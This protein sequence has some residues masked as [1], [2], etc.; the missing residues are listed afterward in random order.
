MGFSVKSLLFGGVNEYVTM[1]NVLDREKTDPFSISYWVK[2]STVDWFYAVSKMDSAVTGYSVGPYADGRVNLTLAYAGSTAYLEVRANG[3]NTN[4]GSWHHVV[5][6]SDGTG[7]SGVSFVIDGVEITDKTVVNDTLGANLITNTGPFN[8]NGRT[9]GA[10]GCGAAMMDEVA[11]YNRALSTAEAAWIY[12]SGE[13]RDLSLVAAPPGLVGWW[14]MGEWTSTSPLLILDSGPSAVPNTVRDISGNNYDG[15]MTSMEAADVVYNA[16]GRGLCAGFNG[17]SDITTIAYGGGVKA[18]ERTDRFSVSWWARYN[19]SGTVCSK[20]S[21]GYQGWWV[22]NGSAGCGLILNNA[23][24]TNTLQK[25]GSRTGAAFSTDQRWHH[26]LITYNGSSSASGVKVYI[27]GTEADS[28]STAYDNLTSNIVYSPTDNFVVGTVNSTNYFNG[29]IRDLAIWGKTLS[30]AEATWLYNS[31]QPRDPYDQ[32][33]PGNLDGWWRLGD[34]DKFPEFYDSGPSA[35]YSSVV[36]QSFNNYLGATVNMEVEDVVYD[37]PGHGKSVMFDGVNEYATAGNVLGYEYTA[38]FSISCWFKVSTISGMLVT[39]MEADLSD[40]LRGYGIWLRPSGAFS[41]FLRN[42]NSS[43]NRIVVTSTTTGLADGTWHHVVATWK[44]SASPVASDVHLY[45]DGVLETPVVEAN[46]LTATITTTAPLILGTQYNST[47]YLNGRLTGVAI[48]SKELSAAEVEWIYNDGV[49]PDLLD[50]GAPSSLA[51][52]WKCGEGDTIPTLQDSGPSNYDATTQNMESYDIVADSPADTYHFAQKSYLFDGVSESVSMGNV[53]SFERTSAFS[54]SFWFKCSTPGT[55]YVPL[56]KLGAS[57]VGYQISIDSSGRFALWLVSNLGGGNYIQVQ[58]VSGYTNS[59]WRHCVVTFDGS[60][61]ATG[62]AIYIDGSPVTTTTVVNSLTGTIVNSNNFRLA[63]RDDGFYPYAGKL[64]EVSVYSRALTASE[65][66]WIYNSGKPRDLKNAPGAPL[67]LVGWWRMGEGG[68]RS[69]SATGTWQTRIL[70]DRPGLVSDF[71]TRCLAFDGGAEY[72]DFGNVLAFERN[73][74]FSISCWARWASDDYGA[75]VAKEDASYIGYCLYKYPGGG[76]AFELHGTGGGYINTYSSKWGYGNGGWHH[77]VATYD[78]SSTK[79]GLKLYIDNEDVNGGGTDTLVASIVTTTSLRIGQRQS[80]LSLTGEVDEVS[81]YNKQ[82][83]STEVSWIFNSGIPR[84]LRTAEAPSNL[85]GWWRLG[86]G[87]YPGTMTNMEA[88]DVV[89]DSPSPAQPPVN[90]FDSVTVS[91][92]A[93]TQLGFVALVPES[94]AVSESAGTEQ[95]FLLGLPESVAVSESP[96]TNQ[97]Y[98]LPELSESASISDFASPAQGQSAT[99]SDTVGVSESTDAVK[100]YN[101]TSTENISVAD[102]IGTLFVGTL[103]ITE[104]VPLS[105]TGGPSKSYYANVADV[106][107]V[108]EFLSGDSYEEVTEAIGFTEQVAV[109]TQVYEEDT[110]VTVTFPNGIQV[111]RVTDLAR[112]RFVPRDGTYPLTPL[113]AEPIWEVRASG[114]G[115]ECYATSDAPFTRLFRVAVGPGP[116]SAGD[117][118]RFSTAANGSVLARITNAVGHNVWVAQD[119]VA[120]DPENGSITWDVVRVVGVRIHV[121]KPLNQSWHWLYLTGLQDRN[122][123]PFET[124]SEF[125]VL[126]NKPTLTSAEFLDEGQI[127][128]TFSD[129]M[130]NDASLTDP[131]EYTV[132]GPTT[133]RVVSVRMLSPTQVFLQTLGMA[134]GVYTVRVNALGTPKDIAGNPID[135]VFNEAVFTGSEPTTL[136]SVFTDK[137]PIAK[138]PLT[139]QS[140][141]GAT[142]D[143]ATEITLPG[144]VLVPSM[145][146]KYVT[147]SGVTNGG[148]YLITSVITT[149]RAK[150]K[151]SFTY[152]DPDSGT[153]T[154]EVYDPRDGQ[155]ADDPADVS[156]TVNSAPITPEAVIGLLG[157]IVLTSRPAP[158]DDVQVGYSWVCNPTVEVRRL[159]SKEF[160]LNSWNRDINYPNDGTQHKYRYN[161]ILTTPDLYVPDDPQAWLDQPQQR[162][163]KYR[164]YERAYSALLND[165]NLLLLNSP[166]QKIAFPPLQ[167]TIPSTFVSYDALVL[168]EDDTTNPWTREGTGTASV[169]GGELL[170][171]DTQSG[172][173]PTGQPIFWVRP[174]DLTFDHVFAATWRMRISADPV[175]EGV[176]TGVAMGYSGGLKTLLIGYLDDAGTKKLGILKKGCGN[177]LQPITAW[178][179][180]LSGGSSTGAP[181]TF[182]WSILHSFRIYRDRMGIVRVY[183]DGGISEILRVSEDD[184]PFLEELAAPFDALEGVF[185]GSLSRPALNTSHWNFVRYTVLPTNPYQTAPSVFVSYEGTAFPESASQPWTPIGYHGTETLLTGGY[186]LLDSTSATDDATESLVG[187]IGGDFKGFLRMEPLLDVAS[188]IMLDVNVQLR[189][190]THGV[191]PN[192][193]TAAIDDGDRLMQLS[194]LCDRAAPKLSYGGRSFPED[195]TPVPWTKVATGAATAAMVGRTLR[196]TDPDIASGLIYY[197][198]DSAPDGSDARII[199]TSNEYAFEYRAQVIS[200]TA[201]PGGFCGVTADVYDSYATLGV[202]LQEVAG[203]R[204]VTLHSDGVPVVG[205]QFAF[206]WF[207]GEPHTYRVTKRG[208]PALV[209]LF[210]D[211]VYVGSVDYSLF[212]VPSPSLPTGVISFGSSTA[213]STLARSVV[214]WI[215]CNTWRVLSVFRKYVGLW[216]GYDPNALT[217]YHL[218]T[219]IT[220][221]DALVMGNVLGDSLANFFA[222]SVVAG[223]LLIV[224][225]GPNKGVYEVAAVPTASTLT[226]SGIFPH[227]PSQVTYRIAKETDWTTA[228]KYRLTKDAGG[229]VSVLLDAITAP[230][231]SVGYNNLE[232]PSSLVGIFRGITG[233]LPLIAF[234]AF[235]PTNISQTAWDYVRFGIVRSPTELR[236]VPH[237]QILNQRNV[238]AS[239]EHLF[240]AI[241]HTHTDYWSSST[242]IPPQTDPD[243]LKN[244]GLIAF[245]LLNEGTPLVPKTQTAETRAG[246][247]LLPVQQPIAGLNNPEDV[248]GSPAFVLNEGAYQWTLQVPDD[249]LYTDGVGTKTVYRNATPLP[250]APALQTEATFKLKLLNDSS[251]GAGDTQVR[252]GLSAPG[253]TLALLFKTTPLGERYVLVKDMNSGAIVGG[254]PFDFGDGNYHTYRIVRN[255][256]LASV[257][258]FI[259]P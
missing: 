253:M 119:L 135:L 159:N 8:I 174:V 241:A 257:Q 248:L 87:A 192:A 228:H 140:G 215:Y 43:G 68:Y 82:L 139:L 37:A 38:S 206:D 223:D 73:Q 227:N 243:F 34:G 178:T 54:F 230:I 101:E 55:Y 98:V 27:D 221:R 58:T 122:G 233:G 24:G 165:P 158:M 97:G 132:T 129:A 71:A 125:T 157:Q 108:S 2:R 226:I 57:L 204:Y 23:Y 144:S 46:G 110:V 74:P 105:E 249:V 244:P 117:Y 179:G 177:N 124:S 45:L 76:V 28:Y 199:G 254:V 17:T 88:G 128:L 99:A 93:T 35:N 200:Y 78:G 86:E 12:N 169:S 197:V 104:N 189:T 202:L 33:Y 90:L 155:I 210:I 186:L 137:G 167:R 9:N 30:A 183:V 18:Y 238:M 190:W 60:S 173:F 138:P 52:W 50:V 216:K 142:I 151:A 89:D 188:D 131:R 196:V 80:D 245:T 220:G 180:G 115:G 6:I 232:L 207:D 160:R 112:Y 236:I 237:H 209:S 63:S 164:A 242:G 62:V 83:T 21:A 252:F 44:G 114:S 120:N 229:S 51:A 48:H 166:T 127:I 218:P 11:F 14:R 96:A 212:T 81:I 259:D 92:G 175:D 103:P 162:D 70:G 7:G 246:Y 250:D 130:R 59:A 222:S 150:V 181:I 102:G 256:A 148:D 29:R 194:F 75:L 26:F 239:P 145:V 109:G 153:L 258:V 198:D 143:S 65:V 154:W 100:G 156:V 170:V 208:G 25:S 219:K 95:D 42:T 187:L 4:D 176:F 66:S 203:V 126:A 136:R 172:P 231:I 211:G 5:V 217:G 182:D 53:L 84:D 141:T 195:W 91:D 47:S 118:L 184:L 107:S 247:D 72:V 213:S 16:P 3:V 22:T 201:D 163:L 1:G 240:T 116:G 146:G 161:N 64:D 61:S 13:P 56:A 251:G 235:D 40:I 147:L 32:G 69:S 36:D 205:G 224:D 123:T 234:G 149:T 121:S 225:V 19:A 191:A 15:T 185:F 77:I 171:Q 113:Y 49:P 67:S 41:L 255:I 152:P 106:I 20:V 10:S 79:A 39:K 94:V 31:G 133:V 85:Q 111:D 214:D 134:A 193:I 168:P